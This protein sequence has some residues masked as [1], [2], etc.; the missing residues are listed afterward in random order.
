MTKNLTIICGPT[1]SGK[2]A[3]A[4]DLAKEHNGVVIN[5]DSMQVYNALPMLTAQPD[6]QDFASV[7]HRL[8]GVLEPEK[9]CSAREWC[10]LAVAEIERTWS[11]NQHPVIVGGT[12]L[13]IKALMEGL[14]PIPDVPQDIRTEGNNLQK[15]L[16]NPGFHE[17]LQMLDPD[18]ASRLNPNDT[19]RLIRAWEVITATGQSLAA[20]Q[21]EPLQGPPS[22]WRFSV[23]IMTPERTALHGR[24][25][26]RFDWMMENGALQEVRDFC[27]SLDSGA[28]P[29]D[30]PITHALGFHPL[31]DHLKGLL[32]QAKAIEKAKIETRQYAKRQDTW[33]RHQIREKENIDSIQHIP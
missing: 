12:G 25:N 17:M 13:Y 2:S 9:K 3:L 28:V 10:D 5:A 18:M 15:K 23:I 29:Q 4:V 30:A 19:Q 8:Y 16:G 24:C 6:P 20:W 26:A 27:E 7:P 21:N 33:F 32:D 14:S 22:D 31:Q 1:A 11:N